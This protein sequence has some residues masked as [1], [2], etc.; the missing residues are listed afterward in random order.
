MN[1]FIPDPGRGY[2]PYDSYSADQDPEAGLKHSGPGIA[3]L[4]IIAAAIIGY[5]TGLYLIVSSSLDFVGMT[6]EEASTAIMSH[7]GAMAGALLLLLS[8]LLNLIS[9]I[10]GVIGIL[11]KGRKRVVPVLGTVFSMLPVLIMMFILL[12]AYMQQ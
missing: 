7:T 6:Q 12:I 11:I 9:I 8:G 4:I 10:L 2:P 3:S 5:I 1:Y